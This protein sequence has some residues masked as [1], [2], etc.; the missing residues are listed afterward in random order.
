MVCTKMYMVYILCA[1]RT[2]CVLKCIWC[3]YYMLYVYT[4][5]THAQC[6]YYV[7][8]SYTI[9]VM[10]TCKCMYNVHIDVYILHTSIFNKRI[11]AS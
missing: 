11:P 3:I 2:W 8:Y 6:T 1:L 4:H 9:Y 7:H 10:H 5:C